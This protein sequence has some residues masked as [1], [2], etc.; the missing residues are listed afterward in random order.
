[1]AKTKTTA[2]KAS[3]KKGA[4]KETAKKERPKRSGEVFMIEFE[5]IGIKPNF[6]ERID[7]GDIEELAQSIQ[8]N[9]VRIP[10]RG[11][12]DK[13]EEKW[14]IT[15]GH[16]RIKAIQLLHEREIYILVPIISDARETDEQRVLGM[17][18]DN[19]GKKFNPVEEAAVIYRLANDHNFTE[20][21]IRDKTGFTKVY[22]CNLKLLHNAPKKLKDLIINNV[23]SAT[24]AMK[25]L[26]EEKDYER[27]QEII[28]KTIVSKGTDDEGKKKKITEKDLNKEKGKQNSYSNLRKVFKKFDKHQL[29]P[30]QDKVELFDFAKKINDGELSLDTILAELFEPIPDKKDFVDKNQTDLVEEILKNETVGSHS[31]NEHN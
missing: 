23:V 17:I 5:K 21:Q 31:E 14:L 12:Y 24:L 7:Y 30:R 18:T 19:S 3:V 15:S 4:K 1:M 20:E 27:A 6:N 26:R 28:E 16:R 8:E 22:I 29:T 13:L 9:G 25:V 11:H 10:L 2:K